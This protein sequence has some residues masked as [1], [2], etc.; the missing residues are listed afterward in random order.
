[1]IIIILLNQINIHIF[2][3]YKDL[4]PN[5]HIIN[6]VINNGINNGINNVIILFMA[7]RKLK[8]KNIRSLTK[9]SGGRSYGITLPK[10]YISKLGWRERQKLDVTLVGNRIIIRDWKA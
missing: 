1:M 2:L 8:D 10:E 9:F 5:L 7:N 3:T 6:P 4:S